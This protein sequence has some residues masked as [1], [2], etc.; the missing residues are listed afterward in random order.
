MIGKVAVLGA[1]AWGT[2]WATLLA[3]NGY[4]VSLW[5]YEP[6]VV[7]EI[8]ATGINKRYLPSITLPSGIT[9]TH[10]LAQALDGATVVFEA[11]PVAFLRS[12]LVAAKPLVAP[13][14]PWVMLS[15]GIEQRTL[16]L[17]LQVIADVLG[18]ATPTA[19]VSGPTFAKE[20]AQKSISAATLASTDVAL[21]KQL[22]HQL[23]N[24]YMTLHLSDDPIGVQVGGAVKNVIALA[25][26][27]AHGAGYGHNT[28]AYLITMGLVEVGA[29]AQVLGGKKETLYGLSGLGDLVLT[30]T[31]EQSKNL[32]VGTMLGSGKTFEQVRQE[33]PVLPEG[34]NTVESVRELARKHSLPLPLCLGVHACMFQGMPFVDLVHSLEGHHTASI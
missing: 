28:T 19:V 12:I 21:T 26:G 16:N 17:P 5:C 24:D 2:A 29:L 3:N 31:G 11:V 14:V 18:A 4:A 1:G 13:T 8:D 25:V 30:C 20:L 15:K 34:V 22:I 10:D 7:A 27:M 32:R 6:D 9:P 23:N 33:V